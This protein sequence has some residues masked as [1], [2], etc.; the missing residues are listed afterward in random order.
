MALIL[1]FTLSIH[2]PYSKADKNATLKTSTG[3]LKGSSLTS[4]SNSSKIIALII[5]RSGPV[6]HERKNTSMVNNSLKMLPAD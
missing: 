6:D 2:K 5:T 3:N 4:S 1:L